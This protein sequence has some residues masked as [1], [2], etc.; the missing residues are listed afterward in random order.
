MALASQL[1]ALCKFVLVYSGDLP[2]FPSSSSTH[3]DV[4]SW[5]NE[6]TS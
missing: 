3:P 6:C 5:V 4:L 1:L 2:M